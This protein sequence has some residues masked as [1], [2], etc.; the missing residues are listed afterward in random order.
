MENRAAKTAWGPMFQVALEQLVPEGQRVVHDALVYRFMPSY[1]WGMVTLCRV[2]FVRGTLLNLMD[3][4]VPGI[5]GG[6]W[7]ALHISRATWSR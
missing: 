2:D 1:L 6:I 3:R 4:K 5:R 7:E